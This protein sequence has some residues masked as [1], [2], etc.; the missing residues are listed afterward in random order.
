[1]IKFSDI[2]SVEKN[3]TEPKARD[4]A[5]GVI[6]GRFKIKKSDD[7]KMLAFGFAYVSMIS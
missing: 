3:K 7:D 2:I 1:M 5:P 4:P 6:K